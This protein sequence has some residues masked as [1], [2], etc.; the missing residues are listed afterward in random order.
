VKAYTLGQIQVWLSS[1]FAL[2]LLCWVVGAKRTSGILI[3]LICLVKPHFGAF[4]A[5]ALVRREGPFVLS[6]GVTICIGMA[7]SVATF[8]WA[9]HVDYVRAVMH[10]AERGEAF[11]PNQSVNGLMNRL[12]SIGDPLQYSNLVFTAAF[13]PF[14]PW[15]YA[16]TAISSCLVLLGA[17][18]QWSGNEDRVLDFGRMAVS[19]TIASPIAWEHHYGVLL[20]VFAVT[21]PSAL[22]NR[23]RLFLLMASYVLVSTF[24]PAANLLAGTLWN[25]SQSLLLAGALILLALLHWPLSP[26]PSPLRMQVAPV[27]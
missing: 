9:D 26:R 14:N 15:V 8:G 18:I 23:N 21:L 4:L 3:G 7:L 6:F 12:M 13:P 24:I 17:I 25:V 11:Y 10:M 22:E 2:S 1:L 27:Q 19:I 5:W 20:P 16:A